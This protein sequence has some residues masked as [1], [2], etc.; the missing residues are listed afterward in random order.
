MLR[1]CTFEREQ[2]RD[3]MVGNAD[4]VILAAPREHANVVT[5]LV[6]IDTSCVTVLHCSEGS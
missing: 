2:T 3:P 4:S 5:T 1:V 6:T